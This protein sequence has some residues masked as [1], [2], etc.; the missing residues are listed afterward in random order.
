MHIRIANN[1]RP[2]SENKTARA[3]V[4]SDGSLPLDERE[5]PPGYTIFS[6]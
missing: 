2:R 1:A 4:T 6:P 5:A 3:M